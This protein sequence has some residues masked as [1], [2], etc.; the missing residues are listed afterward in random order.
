MNLR[1]LC[2]GRD[3]QLKKWNFSMALWPGLTRRARLALALE[4][5]QPLLAPLHQSC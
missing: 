3:H 1:K 4:S 5:A 2:D